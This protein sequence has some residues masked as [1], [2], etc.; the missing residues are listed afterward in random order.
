MP[1]KYNLIVSYFSFKTDLQ[2]VTKYTNKLSFTEGRQVEWNTIPLMHTKDRKHCKAELYVRL[3]ELH[4]DES[5]RYWSWSFSS[6]ATRNDEGKAL[7]SDRL[8]VQGTGISSSDN[9]KE[10]LQ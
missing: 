3:V 7:D 4:K 8:L 2:W 1:A 6:L 9:E 10:S 5:H